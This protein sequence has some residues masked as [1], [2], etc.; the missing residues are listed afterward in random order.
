MHPQV[1]GRAH[2]LM[3]L[4]GLVEHMKAQDGVVFESLGAYAERWRA[5][6]P[7]DRWL[8]TNPIQAARPGAVRA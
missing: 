7:V 1:I 3:M 5:E 8:A 6:N 4:E 2:R